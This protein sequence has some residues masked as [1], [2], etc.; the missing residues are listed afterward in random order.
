MTTTIAGAPPARPLHRDPMVLGWS[1]ARGISSIGDEIWYVALSWSAVQLGSPALAGLV[2]ACGSVPHA[3]L[4]LLGGAFADRFNTR[5]LM[6]GSDLARVVVLLGG[7]LTLAVGGSSAGLLITV[8]VLFGIVDA[9]YG[10]AS[11][12]LPRQ[13]VP[14]SELGRLAG[15]RQFCDRI[16][17][18]GGAPLGGLIVAAWGLGG[19]M[20]ADAVSFIVIALVLIGVRPRWTLERETGGS[21]LGDVRDGLRYLGQ[22]P[23]VR[24]LVIALSGLNVFMTPVIA[25]GVVVRAQH[26]G[27]GASG[28]GLLTGTLGV[29]AAVGTAMAMKWRPRRSAFTGLVILFTQP[30]AMVLAGFAPLVGVFVAM[31]AVGIT[32]GLASPMLSGAFQATVGE[33]YLGRCGAVTS[34]ADAALTPL[35]LSGFG[36]LAGVAGVGASCVVFALGYVG[37]LAYGVTRPHLRLLT[38]D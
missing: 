35:A 3:L 21:A 10:P 23:R 6:I 36:V 1:V 25:V 22:T 28:V 16:G 2:L 34:T 32:A 30:M 26:E 11:A 29:G 19:A 31:A 24:D 4:L 18:F 15:I 12:T 27:W 37:L 14:K 33:R 9:I 8:A 13:L 7:L 38:V 5:R 20:L 17:T